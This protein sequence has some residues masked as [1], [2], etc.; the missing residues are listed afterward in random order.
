MTRR[1]VALILTLAGVALS[2]MACNDT[3]STYGGYAARPAL[4]TPT[5]TPRT[6]GLYG[7]QAAANLHA[8]HAAQTAV[9]A[10]LTAEAVNAEVTAQARRTVEAREQ[11]AFEM[12]QTAVV[13]TSLASEAQAT[14]TAQARATAQTEARQ[15]TGTAQAREATA[16]AIS[17]QATA[18]AQAQNATATAQ[19]GDATA[20]AQARL[21][22]L[23]GTSVA[24]TAQYVERLNRREQST[25]ALR[26]YG[27]WGLLALALIASGFIGWQLLPVLVARWRVIRRK[28][29]E[30]EP[31]VMLEQ[32]PD[33]SQRIALPLRSFWQWFETGQAPEPP[34]PQLQ[35]RVAARQQLAAVVQAARGPRRKKRRRPALPAPRPHSGQLPPASTIRVVEPQTVQPWIEDVEGQLVEEMNR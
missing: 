31:L 29:G 7:T 4:V 35:D 26:A 12:T 28:A 17:G 9:A 15:A 34:P 10:Q 16:T 3:G 20:T 2:L 1:R 33:G 24:A 27:P 21:D 14:A 5:P 18:T 6:L 25:Q 8:D 32:G 11:W 22:A 30:A 19:A 23:E 13:G